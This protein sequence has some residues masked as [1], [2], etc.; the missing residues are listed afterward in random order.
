MFTK[1]FSNPVGGLSS[2]MDD[3]TILT[4]V[5]YRNWLMDE[6]FKSNYLKSLAVDVGCI[7]WP[8]RKLVCG[9]RWYGIGAQYEL[10]VKKNLEQVEA[11]LVGGGKYV[12]NKIAERVGSGMIK[13]IARNNKGGKSKVAKD[14]QANPE[15][16]EKAWNVVV[17]G[18]QADAEEEEE[19]EADPE[20]V[21]KR[22]ESLYKEQQFRCKR[23][24][25]CSDTPNVQTLFVL[26]EVNQLSVANGYFDFDCHGA[27]FCGI[28]CVDVAVGRKPRFEDYWPLISRQHANNPAMFVGTDDFVGDYGN[29]KGVNVCFV[30]EAVGGTWVPIVNHSINPQWKTVFLCHHVANGDPLSPDN[31]YTLICRQNSTP[32]NFGFP[33]LRVEEEEV[34]DRELSFTDTWKTCIVSW[35]TYFGMTKTSTYRTIVYGNVSQRFPNNDDRRVVFDRK[36]K[37]VVQDSYRG[38]TIRHRRL[39]YWSW[40]SYVVSGTCVCLLAIFKRSPLF[41][42]VGLHHFYS[43]TYSDTDR[44]KVEI[45]NSVQ[46]LAVSEVRCSNCYSEMQA[47][48]A[49]GFDF[50]KALPVIFRQREVNTDPAFGQ[51]LTDSLVYMRNVGESLLTGKKRINSNMAG[52]VAYEVNGRMATVENIQNIMANQEA[53]QDPL[54]VGVVDIDVGEA[55]PLLVAAGKCNFVER[56]KIDLPRRRRAIAVAPIGPMITTNGVVTP[57]YFPSTGSDSVLAAFGGRS[58]NKLPR[59]EDNDEFMDF[60]RELVR[61]MVNRTLINNAAEPNCVEFFKEHYRKIKGVKY[62]EKTVAEYI[63]YQKGMASRKFSEH[64]C[65]VKFERSNKRSKKTGVMLTKPRLIMIMADCMLVECCPILELFH[66]WNSGPFGKYQVKDLDPEEMAHRIADAQLGPHSVTDYSSFESSIDLKMM[67]LEILAMELLCDK[68]G[69]SDVKQSINKYHGKARTL[70]HKKMS[71]VIRTRCSGDFWTSFGNGVVNVCVMAYCHFKRFGSLDTFKVLAE[72]DDGLVPLESLD[73]NLIGELGFKFS[74]ALTGNQPGDTDFLSARWIDGKR[75]PNIGKVLSGLFWVKKAAHLKTSKQLYLL[76]CMAASVNAMFPGHPILTEAV[77]RIGLLTSGMSAF[78]GVERYLDRWKFPKI[79]SKFPVG[80]KVDE[81][82]R[83]YVAEGAEGFPGIPIAI[84]FELEKR[85]REDVDFFVGTLL[86]D[87]EIVRE[88]VESS[89]CLND[90]EIKPSCEFVQLC[91]AIGSRLSIAPTN[92]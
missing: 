28:S 34:R 89:H 33:L 26:S 49:M 66:Q 22:A 3:V 6:V 92:L 90:D 79:V 87:Y 32:H 9:M 1:Y 85:L 20:E 59:L 35:L 71:L 72:G 70:K 27:P 50:E 91:E 21:E 88:N 80:L 69:W 82:L 4:K 39:A 76:R 46:E 67:E 61:T 47:T 57:G 17:R 48:V 41:I 44:D 38:V 74:S 18:E 77:N 65:F 58:M 68:A 78:K 13:N 63:E 2:F 14:V 25:Q 30:E 15:G 60:S 16:M 81:S 53:G 23:Q 43:A 5:V 40:K 86:D 29:G 54:N 83:P 7:G 19:A 36:E 64:R 31:H 52:M 75:L 11:V 10:F 56:A 62:V 42:G 37:I 55:E 84:Q 8:Q 24:Y 12:A 73:E 45:E 51:V